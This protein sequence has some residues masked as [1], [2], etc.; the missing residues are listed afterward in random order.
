MFG[1]RVMEV[2]GPTPLLFSS[3]RSEALTILVSG[4]GAFVSVPEL[5][6]SIWNPS[7]SFSFFPPQERVIRPRSRDITIAGIFFILKEFIRANVLGRSNEKYDLN[8]KK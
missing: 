2:M 3:M 7:V 8:H 5:F 1:S 4:A 6:R